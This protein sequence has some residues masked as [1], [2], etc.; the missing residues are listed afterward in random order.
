VSKDTVLVD[1]RFRIDAD[2][3]ERREDSLEPAGA[4][5]GAAARRFIAPP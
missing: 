1:Y 2:T 4:W 3:G 5:R